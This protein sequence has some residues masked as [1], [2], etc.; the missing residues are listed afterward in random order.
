M[1]RALPS[2]P[3]WVDARAIRCGC[4]LFHCMYAS[5]Y[6]VFCITVLRS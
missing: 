6:K 1:C 2:Q 3:S 4:Y 5:S